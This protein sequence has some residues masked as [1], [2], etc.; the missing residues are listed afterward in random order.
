MPAKRAVDLTA[1]VIL[2]LALSPVLFTVAVA[3]ALTSPGPVLIRRERTGLGGR[4]F[5]MLTFR[6][7]RAGPVRDLTPAGRLLRR[8]LLDGLPQLLN[9]ARGEMSLVGP[10]PLPPQGSRPAVGAA[11]ARLGVRPGITGLWQVS[12]RSELPWEEMAVLDLHYVEQH[13]LG[14]DLLILART[15]PAAVAGRRSVRVA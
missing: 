2:L 3:V 5:A 1:S 4:T 8:H 14:L 9:V 12:G 11:R 6:T 13:W 10:R 7:R 15:V